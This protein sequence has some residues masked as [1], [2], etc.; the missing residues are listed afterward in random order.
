M[1]ASHESAAWN[2]ALGV[3]FLAVA[4]RPRRAYGLLPVLAAF[5]GALLLLS[6]QDLASG[7]VAATRLLTHLAAAAALALVVAL[8]R[9]DRVPPP[10]QLVAGD[11]DDGTGLRRLRTVA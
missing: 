1:H 3:A 8:D 9:V 6:I 10:E 7:A 4:S 2:L 5:V 11:E